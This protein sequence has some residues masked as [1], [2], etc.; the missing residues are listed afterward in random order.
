MVVNRKIF[1]AYF[2]GINQLVREN[3]ERGE[4][5]LYN[6]RP[7]RI[8]DFK[9]GINL[10]AEMVNYSNNGLYI[11]AD[12][13]L[14]PREEIFVGIEN[15]PLAPNDS[16]FECYRAKVLWRKKLKDSFYEYGYGLRFSFGN[17]VG[18]AEQND[19]F[20]SR[21]DFRK[22]PRKIYNKSII[23]AAQN[24]V[25]QGS[26]KDIS[27]TGVFIKN[28]D[29]FSERQQITIALPLKNGREKKLDGI[30]VRRNNEGVGVEFLSRGNK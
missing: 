7:I 16:V 23:F 26:I 2:W 25:Y 19:I 21:K 1:G 11:E 27:A 6:R 3:D 17:D 14:Q 24:Q 5:R 15:S 18:D 30:I 22:R 9:A 8:E 13:L 20:K 28:K 12:K 4:I 29:R 10:N